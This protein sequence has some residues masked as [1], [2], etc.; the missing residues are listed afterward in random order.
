VKRVNEESQVPQPPKGRRDILRWFGPGLIFAASSIGT[1]ELILTTRAASIYQWSFL[2]CVPLIIFSKA[3][4]TSLML[5]YGTVTGRNF[6]RKVWDMKYLRWVIPY[7]M[8]SSLLYLAGIGAHVGVT[9]GTLDLLFPG[10]LTTHLWIGIVVILVAI[11]TLLGAYGILEKLMTSLAMIISFGVIAVVILIAPSISEMTTGL[12]PQMPPDAPDDVALITWI[13][14][15]GWLGAGWGPTLSYVW[16]AEEKGVG[17]YSS[18]AKIPLRRLSR[19]SLNRM[20]GWLRIVHLDLSFSYVI[21]FIASLCL[22]IAGATVLYPDNLHPQGLLLVGTLSKLFTK[23]IGQWAYYLFLLSAFAIILSSIIGVVDGLSRAMR[24]CTLIVWP[25]SS[26][27]LNN[28]AMLRLYK[29]IAIG[30]PLAFLLMEERPIWLLLIS[31]IM[32]APAIGII[33]LTTTYLCFKLPKELQPHT[34]TFAVTIGTSIIMI[35]T[36]FWQL[37]F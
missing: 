1:G 21:T 32:F 34:L 33:F 14:M 27:K 35:T 37:L 17:M 11:V 9:A 22:Y 16:W 12:V 24:E 6:L 5:R 2:W 4:S 19:V 36:S 10:V 13:G 15:L 3:I 8:L 28:K 20:K 23:T 31:S 25:S 18:K 26:E 29:L 30:I 7:F